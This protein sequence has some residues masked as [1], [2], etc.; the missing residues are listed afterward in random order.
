MADWVLA[1]E[2][3]YVAAATGGAV[4]TGGGEEHLGRARAALG[5]VASRYLAVGTPRS[6]G[7]VVDSEPSAAE[8]ALS[9][10]AH[11]TWFQPSDLRCAGEHA[12]ELARGIGGRVTSLAEAMACDI[13]CLHAPISVECKLLRRGTH[14]NVLTPLCSFEADLAHIATIT[15]EAPGLAELAAGLVDGRQLDEITVFVLGDAQIA[16]AAVQVP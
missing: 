12:E 8:A 11:R 15:H 16:L 6:L 9:V 14:V 5:A 1:T 2:R 10:F 4:P 7:L 3:A 13:V